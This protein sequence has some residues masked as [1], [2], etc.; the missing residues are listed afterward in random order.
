MKGLKTYL[1]NLSVPFFSA[2][3][4]EHRLVSAKMADVSSPYFLY[5]MCAHMISAF[6][7]LM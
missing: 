1:P 3:Q 4:A 5:Y 7:C 6:L 2:D